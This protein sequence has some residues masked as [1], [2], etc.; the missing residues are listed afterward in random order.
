VFRMKLT[1][2]RCG[3]CRGQHSLCMSCWL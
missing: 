2:V 3:D 1:L